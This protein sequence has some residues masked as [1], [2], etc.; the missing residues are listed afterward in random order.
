LRHARDHGYAVGYFES[1]SIDSLQ[2]VI[3]AAEETQSPIII[4]FN[5]EFLTRPDRLAV[6]RIGWYGALGRAAAESARVPCGFIFNECP[7]DAPVRQ[8]VTAGFNL[9]MP[10]P[11]D[12]ES[13]S[14]Y[15][16]RVRAMTDYAHGNGVAVEAEV[17]E[18]P[19]GASGAGGRTTN[20]AAAAAFVRQTGID[21]LAVSVGNIHV[22]L[23]GRQDLN[24]D[25]LAAI[26]RAVDAPLVLHGGTGISAESIR[27][28]I[29]LGV[30][31]VNYGT[32]IKQ[33]Y[34]AA[35]RAALDNPDPNPHHLLGY[36]GEADVMVAGR[37]AVR[38]AV[39]ERIEYLNCVG[40]AW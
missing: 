1:W 5:G 14:A 27:E 18:L 23:D 9:V 4:G 13:P 31:K 28:A 29:R 7:L 17:G 33:R 39:L 20:P 8:A 15:V 26:Q 32:Y 2:G 3:D 38:E 40:R 12:S 19:F 16:E 11:A 35:L 24:L 6:E 36:G 10:I 34:L 30:T 21:L 22:L 25:H 37:R